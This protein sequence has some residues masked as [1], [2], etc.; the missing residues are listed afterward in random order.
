MCGCHPAISLPP[1]LHLTPSQGICTPSPTNVAT[2]WIANPAHQG[3]DPAMGYHATAAGP[4]G[5]VPP[6]MVRERERMTGHNDIKTLSF[7]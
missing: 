7:P 4:W 3:P 6:Q 5:G 2:M 1:S